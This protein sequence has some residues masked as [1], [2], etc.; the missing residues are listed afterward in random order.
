MKSGEI[1]I[2]I[3]TPVYNRA[4]CIGRCIES[5]IS[6]NHPNLEMCIVND[7]S[8]DDT[9]IIVSAYSAKY[10]AIHYHK[11]EKNRGVN[12]ARNWGITHSTGHFILF[13]DSDDLLVEE[14]LGRIVA[15]IEN[16][17]EHKHFLFM[18]DDRVFQYKKFNIM[19]DRETVLS[20]PDFLL[21]KVYGDFAHVMQAD[22]LKKFPFDE[23]LRIYEGLNFLRIYKE[24]YNQL[25]CAETVLKIDR[26]RA[27]SV[28]NDYRLITVDAIRKKY[29]TAR[30]LIKTFEDDYLKYDKMGDTAVALAKEGYLLGLASSNYDLLFIETFVQKW[31][32]KIPFLYRLI[33]SLR[34]GIAVRYSIYSYSGIKSLLKK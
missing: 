28:S 10:P 25:F 19:K 33:R 11:F 24:N 29:E 23:S 14:A 16:H 21:N 4:D 34:L 2:S 6:Q 30:D 8:S 1:K 27:D 7:G 12:A 15:C 5:V 20:Y 3:I 26:G 13:L 18:Q 32:V 22:L 31:N 9:D 17:P